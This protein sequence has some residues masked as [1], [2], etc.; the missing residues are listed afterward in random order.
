MFPVAPSRAATIL[1][2]CLLTSA[3]PAFSQQSPSSPAVQSQA[4]GRV[5][6]APARR[7]PDGTGS[8][9]GRQIADLL[10]NSAVSQ[11]HWG[12]AVTSLDG[13]PLF[14]LDADKYFRPA[15][16]AK[17]FTTAAAMALLGPDARVTTVVTWD[18]PSPEN[19]FQS[20]LVLH[21]AGDANLSGRRFPY[22]SSGARTTRLAAQLAANGER[23]EAQKAEEDNPL[24]ALDD[25]AEQVR[26]KGI[27]QVNAVVG[28]DTLWPDEPYAESWSV[29][30]L[31]WGYGAPVSALAVNDNEM[32]LT[33]A[34]GAAAGQ[35][36]TAV[37]APHPPQ[38]QNGEQWTKL[39]TEVQTV[40]PGQA[41]EIQINLPLFLRRVLAV[42][43][44][45]PAGKSHTE[46]VAMWAPA[47]FAASLFSASLG[48]HGVSG[49]GGY[50]QQT[51][52]AAGTTPFSVAVH[53]P[54][55]D[56]S[57]KAE[58]SAAPVCGAGCSVVAQRESPS[59]AQDVVVT[60][61]ESQN[62]HAEMLLR[63]LGRAYGTE[64]SFA[65][66]ARVVRQF[67]LNAGID[68]D[69]FVFY[70][71]SGLSSKDLVTPR[72]TA[73]LL[74]Y[75]SQQPWFSA[76]KAALPIGGV[77][78]SL[79]GR[80]PDLPLKGHVFAKTGTLG[81]SRALSGYLDTV[82]G[83]TVIFAVFVDDHAPGTPFDRFTMDKIVAAIRAA[84]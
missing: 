81:E 70:D 46:Q 22:E 45:V 73:R 63:R 82:S 80:F 75:A 21:G 55:G 62:L 72:A 51:R 41:A 49:A 61:K 78:G 24:Q 48:A 53:V 10:A 31:P 39:R 69:D 67:L 9:L 18:E 47:E 30:D 36:A 14:G 2:A 28:D 29:D 17:L 33:L 4:D 35:I 34:P 74:A 42:S 43:G 38:L 59:L 7:Y 84:E 11:A 83:R 40:A 37:L 23:A 68:T 65:Q 25:L 71:G 44:T 58:P 13:T 3:T 52:T 77:D 76:W 16:N 57:P 60:L 20:T 26:A 64:G 27:T 15:S 56:L 32:T 5:H 19:N 79:A 12:I 50:R 1:M 8:K 54:L 6:T 66:G